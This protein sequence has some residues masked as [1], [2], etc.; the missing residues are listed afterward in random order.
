MAQASGLGPRS[1]Q[2]AP[3]PTLE[4]SLVGCIERVGKGKPDLLLTHAAPEVP[5]GHVSTGGTLKSDMMFRLVPIGNVK[6]EK[7]VGHKVQVGGML[8]KEP[9]R[10]GRPTPPAEPVDERVVGPLQNVGASPMFRVR[11]VRSLARRCP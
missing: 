10:L 1:E 4:R 9:P 11:T 7:F 6:L 5:S 2:E 8:E 3:G